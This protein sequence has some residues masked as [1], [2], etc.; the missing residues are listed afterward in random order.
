M[1]TLFLYLA[2]AISSWLML[3]RC[4]Y[5]R[6]GYGGLAMSLVRC[7]LLSLFCRG[8][9]SG[10]SFAPCTRRYLQF[11][12]G[13][14]AFDYV[15]LVCVARQTQAGGGVLSRAAGEYDARGAAHANGRFA[16]FPAL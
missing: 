16:F 6:G 15:V 10:L 11:C 2:M 14:G 5:R 4:C 13:S 8:R 3:S 1:L 7:R 12:L 9:L